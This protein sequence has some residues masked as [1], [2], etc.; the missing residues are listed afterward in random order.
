MTQNGYMLHLFDEK[1]GTRD[2]LKMDLLR[3]TVLSKTGLA[4]KDL[5]KTDLLRIVLCP[6]WIC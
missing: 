2:L 4:Q 3:I 5:L 1:I 6:N